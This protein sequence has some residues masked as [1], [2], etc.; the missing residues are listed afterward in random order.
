MDHV[1]AIWKCEEL[2][3]ERLWKNS[4]DSIVLEFFS[5]E[6]HSLGEETCEGWGLARIW[7]HLLNSFDQ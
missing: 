3:L 4:T 2:E 5:L 7:S 6:M 1:V